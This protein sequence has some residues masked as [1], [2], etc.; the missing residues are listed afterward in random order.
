M[1]MSRDFL[2]RV[3]TDRSHV[4]II[5]ARPFLVVYEKRR[6]PLKWRELEI[7]NTLMNAALIRMRRNRRYQVSSLPELCSPHHWHSNWVRKWNLYQ[8]RDKGINLIGL[9]I[10]GLV[11]VA[12]LH[13]PEWEEKHFCS[14][15]IWWFFGMNR[16]PDIWE[17]V[18]YQV[19]LQIWTQEMER[20]VQWSAPAW[21]ACRALCSISCVK[22]TLASV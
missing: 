7:C 17:V 19:R 1:R 21:A 3:D 16:Q 8:F 5:N 4:W 13:P 18:E 11:G 15:P 22:S 9:F 20:R 2:H 12:W 10:P 6:S 14:L